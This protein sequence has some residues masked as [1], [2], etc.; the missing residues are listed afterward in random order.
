MTGAWGDSELVRKLRPR[1]EEI[2]EEGRKEIKESS[3]KAE[4]RGIG[5]TWR[6]SQ[7]DPKKRKL[8]GDI[9]GLLKG[10]LNCAGSAPL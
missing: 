9:T 4:R 8:T 10:L 1:K 5:V 2:E 6:A 7:G 3:R